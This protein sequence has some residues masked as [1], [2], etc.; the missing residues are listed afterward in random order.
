MKITNHLLNKAHYI[1]SPNYNH[2][3]DEQ[4]IRLI[5]IHCISLPA[6]QFGTPYIQQLFCNQLQPQHHPSFESIVQLQVSAHLVINRQG[7]INQ[8][9]PFNQRAWHAGISCYQGKTG[10]NDYSIGIELEGTETTPYTDQQYQQLSQIIKT[11]I[12]TYPKL[13][14]QQI[15]GHS[16][17]A[18]QRKTDPG[19]SFDWQ[20]LLKLI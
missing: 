8:Y 6:G 16:N 17:I 3:P 9:V 18:P 13:S 14:K 5:V 15:T 7:H 10:C 1:A 11:L 19:E 2:R 4:D 12:K 20:R